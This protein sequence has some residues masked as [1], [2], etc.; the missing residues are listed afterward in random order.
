M[1]RKQIQKWG[2]RCSFCCRYGMLFLIVTLTVFSLSGCGAVPSDQVKDSADQTLLPSAQTNDMANQTLLKP[3]MQN[4]TPDIP[5]SAQID[6]IVRNKDTW[7]FV[8]P[9]DAE[10]YGVDE[11]DYFYWITDMDQNGYLEVIS[12]STTGN[13]SYFDNTYYEVSPDGKSLTKLK[14]DEREDAPAPDLWSIEEY[15][16]G[17]YDGKTGT[18]HYPQWDHTHGSAVDTSDAQLD[19]VLSDGKVTINTISYVETEG[20][21]ESGEKGNGCVVKFYA[22]ARAEKLGEVKEPYDEKTR[23]FIQDTKQESEYFQQLEKLYEQYYEGMQEFTVTSYSFRNIDE[24]KYEKSDGEKITVVSDEILRKRIEGSWNRFGIHISSEKAPDNP[25]FPKTAASD[26]EVRYLLD[27]FSEGKATMQIQE[28][29]RGS[30]S[31]LY[32]VTYCNPREVSNRELEGSSEKEEKKWV[33]K[34][35]K[36]F[37]FYLWVTDTQIYYIP[38]FYPYEEEV[39]VEDLDDGKFTICLDDEE[40]ENAY[41]KARLVFYH[42]IPEYARLVCQEGEMEDTLEEMAEGDHQW[43]EKH[44]EDIRCYRSYTSKGEGYDTSGILQF[45]WKRGEGLIGVRCAAH[46]AGGNSQLFW[47]EAYLEVEDV[48]FSI[49]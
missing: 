20:Y 9:A 27:L 29:L 8:L 6:T 25:F 37:Y 14:T 16:Q 32:L 22:G 18:Y 10:E 12:S 21:E 13:G 2:E 15:S 44:G 24:R 31:V 46:P 28:E 30:D 5:Y 36:E 23:D 43:I 40:I 35:L 39:S 33:K 38:R 1:K 17:Y 4:Q 11:S 42:E 7:C 48:G 45:V 3:G 47:K 26:A 19:T 41:Q 49:D 34:C